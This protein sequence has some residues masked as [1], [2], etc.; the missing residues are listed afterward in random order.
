MTTTT[1]IYASHGVL[2]HEFETQWGI[3]PATDSYD[4]VTVALPDGYAFEE[5]AAGEVLVEDAS[6]NVNLLVETLAKFAESPY[7][8]FAADGTR[9]S[10]PLVV[11]EDE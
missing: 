6:G 8:R 11:M 10:V 2:G 9:H 5:N 7:L 1:K 4:E 3:T